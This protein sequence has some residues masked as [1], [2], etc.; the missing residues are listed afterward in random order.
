MLEKLKKV[1]ELRKLKNVLKDETS[2][3]EKE[4]VFVKVNGEMRVEE[5]RISPD[6]TKRKQEDLLVY[7][8][9]DAFTK[10]QM[11]AAQK[12]SKIQGN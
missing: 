10:V 1:N 4:G 8:I 3:A 2:E 11:K 7:C 5:V 9:N 12:I 6:L